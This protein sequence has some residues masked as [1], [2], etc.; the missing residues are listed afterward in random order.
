MFISFHILGLEGRIMSVLGSIGLVAVFFPWPM[1]IEAYFVLLVS[2][3]VC[4]SSIVGLIRLPRNR[5]WRNPRKAAFFFSLELFLL[6]ISMTAYLANVLGFSF[7]NLLDHFVLSILVTAVGVPL[8]IVG[9][10]LLL[11][12]SF[13]RLWRVL[14]G[15]APGIFRGQ[16][17]RNLEKSLRNRG[18]RKD[19]SLDVLAAMVAIPLVLLILVIL[20]SMGVL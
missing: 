18:F 1:M 3:A 6:M 20:M 7:R 17:R 11:D 9:I 5:T 19:I 16:T 10:L 12:M 4:L 8:G 15:Y 2:V 14:F 13:S